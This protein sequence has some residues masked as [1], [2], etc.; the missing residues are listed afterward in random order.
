M[1][2]L[3]I[4]YHDHV[5]WAVDAHRTEFGSVPNMSN[6]SFLYIFLFCCDI[7][8]KNVVILFIFG[9]VIRHYIAHA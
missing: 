7:A 5:P 4:W 2:F 8:E 6:Y 1:E 9:T 3:Y